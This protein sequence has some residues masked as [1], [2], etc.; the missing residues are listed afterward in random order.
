MKTILPIIYLFLSS[1]FVF[2][3]GGVWVMEIEY[4]INGRRNVGYVVDHNWDD[5]FENYINKDSIFNFEFRNKYRNSDSLQIYEKI[6][7]QEKLYKTAT[8][9]MHP[10]FLVENSMK[11]VRLDEMEKLS[12]KK[13]WKKTSYTINVLTKITLADTNWI[14]K[15]SLIQHPVG[16]EVGCRLEAHNF[17]KSKSSQ[18]LLLEFSDL[19]LRKE[20]LTPKERKKYNK[21]LEKLKELKVVI[22]ELCGC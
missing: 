17:L 1:S 15:I 9:P 12:F 22:V 14:S 4:S 10:F 21:L 13:I 8:F 11:Y 16:E 19:Y 3:A 18:S 7:D 6:I 20:N 2:G 5:K